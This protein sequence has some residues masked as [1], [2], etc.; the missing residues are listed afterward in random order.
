MPDQVSITS[1][2]GAIANAIVAIC[3]LLMTKDDKG[4]PLIQTIITNTDKFNTLV[5]NGWTTLVNDLKGLKL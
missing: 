2:I 3:E 5:G 4:V 1:D